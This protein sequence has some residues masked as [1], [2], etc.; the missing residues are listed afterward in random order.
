MIPKK[1]ALYEQI[2][3]DCRAIAR[4]YI[5]NWQ[6]ID[7]L[8]PI[9]DGAAYIRLSTNE[10]LNV[11]KGSLE[12]QVNITYEE[13][14]TKSVRD[15]VNYRIREFFIEKAIS[16]QR[17]DRPEFLRMRRELKRKKY[18]FV[19]TKEVS[20]LARRQSL[21]TE[22]LEELQEL[23]VKLII[24]GFPIDPNDPNQRFMIQQVAGFAEWEALNSGK[25]I[26]MNNRAALKN[27][28]KFNS[29]HKVLG[30]D[31]KP[32]TVGFYSVNED[33]QKTVEFIFQSFILLRSEEKV[34]E[35]LREKN[36]LNK[37]QCAFTRASLHRLLKNK[38]LIGEWQIKDKS[39]TT[40]I[41]LPHGSIIPLSLWDQVQ[42]ILATRKSRN[43]L[44]RTQR[45][46][47]L[48]GILQS[49]DGTFFRGFSG[50]GRNEKFFYY[51]NDD[52]K[53]CIPARDLEL[54]A[55]DAIR[56]VV[57]GSNEIQKAV[58]RYR[59]QLVGRQSELE[60]RKVKLSRDLEEIKAERALHAKAIS[61]LLNSSEETD[62]ILVIELKNAIAELQKKERQ[63]QDLLD[64]LY[65][66]E[67]SLK[68]K[69]T[70]T[71]DS[72][73]KRLP[74]IADQLYQKEPKLLKGLLAS[75]FRKIVVEPI[76]DDGYYPVTFFISDPDSPDGVS[77]GP[78]LVCGKSE[79]VE[80]M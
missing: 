45:I 28:G 60:L 4:E 49:S 77:S 33:E 67:R 15:Q 12:Q 18:G 46:Y 73:V 66:E 37:G 26:A 3:E 71:W 2:L 30:L 1:T 72:F 80:V 16:G 58:I 19:T 53:V 21:F 34:L 6:P 50:T 68:E 47:F 39:G 25:R 36:I 69:G 48:S 7:P 57:D 38:K 63:Y 35:T 51:R 42:G 5:N 14:Q 32:G 78:Q 23:E 75:F 27:N 44:N 31:R 55:F 29:T 64:D 8:K 9:I 41:K 65:V 40:D 70:F 79:L 22:F 24:P 13:M 10:Q 59:D 54:L 56:D 61:K 20:R 74:Q 17:A 11:A 62:Q 43:R 76:N 52:K